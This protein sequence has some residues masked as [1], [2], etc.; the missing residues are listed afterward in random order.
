MSNLTGLIFDRSDLPGKPNAHELD[1]SE[2]YKFQKSRWGLE[3]EAPFKGV[4]GAIRAG[5]GSRRA[6]RSAR[7]SGEVS[8]QRELS[9]RQGDSSVFP[10]LKEE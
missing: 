9:S 2:F 1:L 3:G 6:S 10:F 4:S 5:E 8:D 7:S